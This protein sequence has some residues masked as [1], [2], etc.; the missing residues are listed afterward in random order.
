MAKLCLRMHGFQ[1]HQTMQLQT[2]I[3][4]HKQHTC[5]SL[6]KCVA[7]ITWPLTLLSTLWVKSS[8]QTLEPTYRSEPLKHKNPSITEINISHDRGNRAG[9]CSLLACPTIITAVPCRA[10]T[11]SLLKALEHKAVTLSS[12]L[13]KCTP[14]D[15]MLLNQR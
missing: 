9:F 2:H 8:S 3:L 13:T 15:P 5:I 10:C 6:C 4:L 14:C 1:L 12:L 7:F 11:N